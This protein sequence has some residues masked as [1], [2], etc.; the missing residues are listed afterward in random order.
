MKILVVEDEIEMQKSI[1][2]YLT[3]EKN[4]VEVANDFNSAYEK[5]QLYEYDCV[6]LDITLPNGNGL[7]LIKTIKNS[8]PKTGIII[9]S[10]K[11][12][13]DDK[14]DGLNL[15]ADD[16]L[17]K[18]FH[19]PELNARIKALIRRNN[20]DG[21]DVIVINEITLYP[22]ERKILINNNLVNLTSKEFDLLV[23]FIANKNRV[24][25]KNALVEHLWGD[26]ADQFDNFDFI[27]NHVKNLRKKLL[28][29]HCSDYI[30]SIY[31]IGYTFKTEL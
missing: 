23:Y 18:P 27:Y 5:I 6:L 13:F 15:G 9:I 28:A 3:L 25:Q 12:S 21:V 17:P 24:I 7:D 10:A 2:R 31:G 30:Q 16:Y 8:R 29:A 1:I 19:L 11:N 22:G 14:I 20:F 4:I 26:N